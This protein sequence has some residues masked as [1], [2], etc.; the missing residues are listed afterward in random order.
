MCRTES[1]PF[2]ID[3]GALVNRAVTEAKAGGAVGLRNDSNL[4]VITGSYQY[5]DY[6]NHYFHEE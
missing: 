6:S 3:L 4:Q 1:G 5:P 2:I